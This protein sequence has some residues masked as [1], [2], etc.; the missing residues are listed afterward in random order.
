MSGKEVWNTLD[1][2]SGSAT[3]RNQ[4]VFD[5]IEDWLNA[6]ARKTHRFFFILFELICYFSK[7]DQIRLCYKKK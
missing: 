7:F 1:L 4:D 2:L 3:R 5:D 6:I